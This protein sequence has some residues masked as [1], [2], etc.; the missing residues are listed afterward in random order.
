MIFSNSTCVY[1]T[2]SKIQFLNLR[3]LTVTERDGYTAKAFN[4]AILMVIE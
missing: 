3:V 4:V 1:E 2:Q